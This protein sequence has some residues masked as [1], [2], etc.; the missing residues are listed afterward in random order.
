MFSRLFVSNLIVLTLGALTHSQRN[1]IGE[2]SIGKQRDYLDSNKKY[3]VEWEAF[4]DTK[5]IIFDLTVETLGFVGFGI[6]PI[7][8]MTGADIIIGGVY[9]NTSSYFSVGPVE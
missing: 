5:T 6:S 8:G 4:T 2:K 9:F 1:Y 7:G 3:L